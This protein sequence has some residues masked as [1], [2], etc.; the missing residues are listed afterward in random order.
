VNIATIS[1]ALEI[2]RE[3]IR[4]GV[5]VARTIAKKTAVAAEPTWHLEPAPRSLRWGAGR[6]ALRA[7]ALDIGVS[8]G[9]C[10]ADARGA[11]C[12][13]V[14]VLGSIAHTVG[15]SVAVVSTSPEV[16]GIGIDV[17][18]TNPARPRIEERVLTD[19]EKEELV[20]VDGEARWRAVL[21][22]F[23]AKEASYKALDAGRSTQLTFRTIQVGVPGPEATLVRLLTPGNDPE[24]RVAVAQG[25]DFTMALAVALRTELRGP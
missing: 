23:C 14:G 10:A 9:D 19:Q 7:A 11:V 16:A 15:V 5:A 3:C 12:L 4:S 21:A 6:A 17:E 25:R 20:C 1:E 22:I 13:P 18:P 2:A 24:A 8:L